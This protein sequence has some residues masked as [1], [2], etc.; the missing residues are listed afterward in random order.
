M[1]PSSGTGIVQSRLRRLGSLSSTGKILDAI[2]RLQTVRPRPAEV[3]SPRE[4]WRTVDWVLVAC[5]G[6][7]LLIGLLALWSASSVQPGHAHFKKQLIWLGMGIPI[8]LLFWMVD[9]RFWARAR[10]L[11]YILNLAL[12]CAVFIPKFGESARGAQRWIDLGPLQFQPSELAKL[13]LVLT[14]SAHFES[15]KEKIRSLSGFLLSLV[16][17]LPFFILVFRQPDLGT[18]LIFLCIWGAMSLVANQRLRYLM[19]VL[20]VGII[21][22]AFAWHGGYVRE[23]QK[24][25]ILALISGEGSYHSRIAMMSVA[26]G[27]ILGE[28]YLKGGVKE[29][30]LVPEQ[31]TDFI[32]VVI[33]EEGG[34][35]GS[36]IVLGAFAAFLFRI[37]RVVTIAS[38]SYD[39]FLATGAFAVFGFH[40][41]VNLAMTLGLFP[42]VGVPLTFMSYGGSALVTSLA[43]LGLILNTQARVKRIVF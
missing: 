18:S 6:F 23:Y 39:A 37:W 19:A 15:A 21:A 17:V 31:T 13:L 32:F 27:E 26:K 2:K 7:L 35:I 28:G 41:L 36:V 1:V 5:A 30:G 33:A 24:E 38:S 29:A 34:F 9:A 16:H 40:I 20:A 10:V 4:W 25:R 11:L 42:I 8:L 22:F 43:L 14:L 3:P 12:L